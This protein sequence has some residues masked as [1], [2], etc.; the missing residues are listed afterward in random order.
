MWTTKKEKTVKL[1][2]DAMF[3]R[4][5]GFILFA[6]YSV[7]ILGS[8]VWSF[9][10]SLKGRM[11]YIES[12]VKLPQKWLF[13]N[14][15]TAFKVLSANGKNALEMLGNSLW[16]SV[17]PPTINLLTASMASY[18]M[19]KYKF[20][21]RSL[22]WGIMITLMIIPIYGSGSA[23][24]KLYRQLGIYDSPLYLITSVTG[25]GGSI[26]MIAA[27]DSVSTAYMEAAFLEGAGHFTIFWKIMLPQISGLLCALWIMS[28]IGRWND[29][30]SA[31]MFLPSYPPL[32]SGLYIYQVEQNR[33]LNTPILLAGSLMCA[34][35]AV[36]LFMI[37]QDKF[38]NL[39]FGGGIKG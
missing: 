15:L 19:S 24:Y 11:E 21:G 14:Y 27:F 9:I 17:L 7:T 16:L 34:I 29:Y 20:P 23:T 4:V 37:F 1:K 12:V 18:V 31:L 36:A 30:M 39:T 33:K 28:F 26:M 8:F 6:L 5:F 2:K 10:N 13:S 3:V 25:L 38:L 35:P 22:I 32:S